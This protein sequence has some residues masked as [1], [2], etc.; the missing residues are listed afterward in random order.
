MAREALSVHDLD[1]RRGTVGVY[2]NSGSWRLF[3]RRTFWPYEMNTTG[4]T[5]SRIRL[6]LS[7][8]LVLAALLGAVA[9]YLLSEHT[10]HV[11]AALPFLLFLLCP[12]MHLFMHHGGHGGRHHGSDGEPPTQGSDSK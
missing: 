10:A 5:E 3:V 11:L 8:R 2:H 7:N 12:L 4:K 9:I 1:Q 6:S